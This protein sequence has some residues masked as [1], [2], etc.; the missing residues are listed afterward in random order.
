LIPGW[1]AALEPPRDL[2]R[3]PGGVSNFKSKAAQ[4]LFGR[5]FRGK[6][7]KNLKTV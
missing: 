4:K 7:G 5:G 1:Q 2:F 3:N 6:R